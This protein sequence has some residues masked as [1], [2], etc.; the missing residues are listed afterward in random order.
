M[1]FSCFVENSL[2]LI[3]SYRLQQLIDF[4]LD[5][6]W[7]LVALHGVDDYEHCGIGVHGAILS[8]SV[9]PHVNW[10]LTARK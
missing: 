2:S 4:A 6:L 10:I 5:I 8:Q 7:I 1:G 3:W 9:G